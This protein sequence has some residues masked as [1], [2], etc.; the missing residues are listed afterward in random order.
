[1]APNIL[2]DPALFE[3]DLT[4]M[5][6][7]VTG[8]NGGIG[9]VTSK[10][11]SKQGATVI[12][13]CRN[14]EKGAVAAEEVGGVFLRLDLASLDSVKE[15]VSAFK[16]DYDR[17][18][19]LVNNAGVMMCP[20]AETVDGFEI[21]FG[22]NHLGHFLLM[23]LLT[24]MLLETAEKTGKP[25]RFLALSSC[26]ATDFPGGYQGYP[27]INFDDL[28]SSADKYDTEFAY[29][30]SKLANYLHATEAG[31]RYPADKLISVSL[32]P[33]WVYTPLDTHIFEKTLGTN[34]IARSVTS[35]IRN[36]L[37]YTG[38]ML[39]PWIG[40]QSTFQCI[41]A[42][43]IQ[44]GKFYSQQG[45]YRDPTKKAGGWPMDLGNIK[46]MPGDG[47]KLW[48]VSEKLVGL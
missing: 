1:M 14:P 31:E 47:A 13:A 6:M 27:W 32:H 9:L 35:L 37:F 5:V 36:I 22:A 42:D 33:G 46:V 28:M 16:K 44:S 25:S 23:R 29:G 41:L 34:I 17:L 43:D 2:C 48:E 8:A 18:D 21:Q 11:L 12:L 24:P 26:A 3:K 40:I 10:Q 15:F 19:V 38:F 4:G 7:V 20:Y 39:T 30:Q 45:M